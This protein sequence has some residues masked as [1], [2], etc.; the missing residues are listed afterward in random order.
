M[1][2]SNIKEKD[3]QEVI[4]HKNIVCTSKK[5]IKWA[6]NYFHRSRRRNMKQIINKERDNYETDKSIIVN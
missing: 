3:A 2:T 5:H 1:K 6:K 4:R